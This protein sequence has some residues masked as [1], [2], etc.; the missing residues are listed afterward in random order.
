[1]Q[2]QIIIDALKSQYNR[3]LRKQIVKNITQH[4]KN[5]DIEAIKSSYKIIDQIF[6]YI[7]SELS[8]SISSNSAKWDDT[9]LQ[10]MSQTFPKIETTKWFK[11]HQM[12]VKNS[13]K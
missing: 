10:I 5:S 6:S 8:W 13:K 11:E 1:M 12:Q 7:I 9:P 2:N 4:E 3:D